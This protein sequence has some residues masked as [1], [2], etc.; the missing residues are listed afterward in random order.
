M[1]RV[2]PTILRDLNSSQ[3]HESGPWLTAVKPFITGRRVLG[4]IDP[5]VEKALRISERVQELE[6]AA[7]F[8]IF[9]QFPP[10]PT[11]ESLAGALSQ[12]QVDSTDTV[13]AIGGG[14]AIDLAKLA[15]TALDLGGAAQL[16]E[17]SQSNLSEGIQRH[18]VQLFAIPTTAGT[19]AEATQ[20]AVLYREGIKYSIAGAA[21]KPDRTVLDASLLSSLPPSVIAD[22]GLD[23]ACQ[24]MESLWSVRS[25]P[26]SEQEAWEAL[27]LAA[28]HLALAVTTQSPENLNAMLEAAHR[29][30]RA[31]NLTT[32][33]APHALS[34]GL[35]SLFG[36]PHGRAVARLYGPIFKRTAIS[37]EA[38]CRHPKGH[39]FL[40]E[41]LKKIAQ[42]WGQKPEDF[43][44]WWK[45]YLQ[46][47][48]SVPCDRVDLSDDQLKELARTVNAK[49]LA[50]H[51]ILF[52]PDQIKD[53]YQETIQSM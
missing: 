31:I 1:L 11:W 39:P 7:A 22:A 18:S 19:G 21:L 10:N 36:I 25:S 37:V 14:T 17:A 34:Y 6:L 30:G 38:Y 43:P 33:S 15:A 3:H 44:E 49:R 28:S 41:R 24:A 51:P 26:E 47:K 27:R 20:F 52:S 9:T 42:V 5:A 4:I 23:A 40:I 12:A 45:D 32:T 2:V 13:I 46:N 53:I 48:L 16:W 29:A 50:N 8:S 35:T